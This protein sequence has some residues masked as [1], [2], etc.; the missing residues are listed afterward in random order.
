MKKIFL[1]FLLLL[2]SFTA[3]AQS[4]Y[5]KAMKEKIAKLEVCKTPQDFASLSND[6]K[7]IADKEKNQWQPY[8]Y[9]AFA[10]IQ[11]GR[12][13]MRENKIADAETPATEAL[14]LA[15]TAASLSK[16]NAEIHILNKMANSLL[17]MKDPMTRY[18][19]YGQTAAQELE[20]AAKLDPENPRLTLLKGEDLYF[21]PEQYG[22]SKQKGM[23]L[24]NKSLEQFNTYKPKTDLD[25]NWGKSEAEYMSKM[26]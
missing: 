16:D 5:E 17:M 1:T 3:F 24:I 2:I 20:L 10:L 4:A 15:G 13:L 23:E 25:P 6:F 22:G 9:A 14:Q 11:Q 18:M 26:K 7:R 19:T 12:V 21:T 8:Y